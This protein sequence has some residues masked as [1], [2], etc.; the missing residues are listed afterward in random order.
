MK[1]TFYVF[2][3]LCILGQVIRLVYEILK[4]NQKINPKNGVIFTLV[5]IGMGLFL[6]SWIF[7]CQVDPWPIFIP[8]IARWSGLL[9]L[10]TGVVLAAGGVIQ[11]RGL[12][13]IDHLVTSGLYAKLR[14]PMYTGFILWITGWIIYSGGLGS[15]VLGIIS[16][17][18]ILYW[19]CLEESKLQ[20]DFGEAYLRYREMTWF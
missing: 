15:V 1:S 19:R 20:D 17:A 4:K 9:I 2:L 14:H 5:F 8:T 6:L 13:N 18:N 16:I 7:L 11:L 12:E 3:L 10:I